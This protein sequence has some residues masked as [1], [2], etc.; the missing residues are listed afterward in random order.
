MQ[1]NLKSQQRLTKQI[2]SLSQKWHQGV[3]KKKSGKTISDTTVVLKY[4]FV[5]LI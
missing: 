4:I 3:E 1:G 2:K 5:E